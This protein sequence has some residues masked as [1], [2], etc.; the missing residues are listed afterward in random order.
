MASR[1]DPSQLGL[2][3]YKQP[4]LIYY[5]CKKGYCE[6][7]Y[8]LKCERKCDSMVFDTTD[9]NSMLF[10]GERIIMAQCSKRSTVNVSSLDVGN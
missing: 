9:K 10:I 1:R 4:K 6:E 2:D 3:D 8:D 7:I 5:Y